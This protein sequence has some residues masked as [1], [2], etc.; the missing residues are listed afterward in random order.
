MEPDQLGCAGLNLDNSYT[1]EPVT[2]Q[3][4][5]SEPKTDQSAAP[6]PITA[7]SAAPEPDIMLSTAFEQNATPAVEPVIDA[8]VK[9]DGL[10]KI[11]PLGLTA[12]PAALGYMTMEQIEQN[13][14]PQEVQPTLA[15][16]VI[17]PY[18]TIDRVTGGG[19]KGGAYESRGVDNFDVSIDE[20]VVKDAETGTEIG[21]DRVGTVEQRSTSVVAL[22]PHGNPPL[23]STTRLPAGLCLHETSSTAGDNNQSEVSRRRFDESGSSSTSSLKDELNSDSQVKPL[24]S[25]CDVA[26]SFVAPRRADLDNTSGVEVNEPLSETV[27]SD[28][29]LRSVGS[30]HPV[31]SDEEISCSTNGGAPLVFVDGTPGSDDF[32]GVRS[33]QSCSVLPQGYVAWPPS[34]VA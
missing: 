3:S 28:S 33:P 12:V 27:S 2:D 31:G 11:K 8:R 9:E 16:S 17:S 30:N 4:A 32:S 15:S 21:Q 10:A 5:A 25:N 20:D 19:V 18:S 29:D 22:Q 7:Q 24:L 14:A 1:L 26:N 13:F 34:A 23:H 6:K